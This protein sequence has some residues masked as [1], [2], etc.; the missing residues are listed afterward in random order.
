LRILIVSQ[1]FYPENFRINDLVDKLI[2]LGHEV[3]VL[4]GLPN[5][6]K[7]KFFNGFNYLSCGLQKKGN[8]KL[9]RVPI[10][11]RFSSSKVQL[12]FNYLSF[13]FSSIMMS[14]FYCREKYD[15][16]FT[17]APSPPT[18]AFPSIILSFFKQIPHVIW[19]QDLWPEVFMAEDTPKK[20]L[21]YKLIKSMM[22]V[23]YRS[24]DKILIP[25]R[26]FKPYILELGIKEEKIYYFPNWAE[27]FFSPIPKEEALNRGI[28]LPGGDTFKLMFAGNIGLAQSFDVIIEAAK[29]L[30]NEKISWIIL[31]DGRKKSWL[32]KEI[33]KYSLED[34]VFTLGQKPV[35]EMPFYF[36]MSDAL[37]VSLRSHPVF[38]AWIPGKIQSYLACGK[39]IIGLISGAGARVINDSGSGF[40]VNSDDFNELAEKI[41]LLIN[42]SSEERE[43]IGSNALEYYNREFNRDKLVKELENIFLKLQ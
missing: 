36:A 28:N 8:L 41:N 33:K 37:L 29:Q 2:S 7:G 23:I 39:P 32:D 19:V 16:I 38:S 26:E 30:K 31:G 17:Y 11:P 35:E 9:I 22:Q 21:F 24:S 4:T 5:Y 18:V 12:V 14:F 10:I 27:K 15:V 6:P 43:K 13:A 42:S 1:Y 25:A 20:G 34:I 3:T 40:S